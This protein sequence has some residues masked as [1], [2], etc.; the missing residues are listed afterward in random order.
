MRNLL[1]VFLASA[2]FVSCGNKNTKD[3]ISELDINTFSDEAANYVDQNIS[4]TG[5]CVHVCRHGGKKMHLIG[6]ND[7]KKLVVFA[8]EGLSEFPMELEGEVLKVT[9]KVVEEQI[10]EET[11]LEWE[12]E[13]AQKN[14]EAEAELTE[15][16]AEIEVDV[17]DGENVEV[18]AEDADLVEKDE[19]DTDIPLE[20][21]LDDVEVKEVE[22]EESHACSE[23]N[24]DP[25]A[26]YR[27]QIAESKDGILRL[28]FIEVSS[29]E[30]V[31]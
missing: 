27:Q 7:E 18:I 16:D 5:T 8:G 26:N 31:K 17:V 25:Y 10:T 1:F 3:A 29:F 30:K 14:A 4:I 2:L 11:I 12:A 6:D 19:I 21:D 24:G 23:D 13:D 15:E 20:A 22:T 9:G 28:Y